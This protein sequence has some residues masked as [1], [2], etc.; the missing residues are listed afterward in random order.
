[1]ADANGAWHCTI[2]TLSEGNHSLIAT[3][4]DASGQIGPA[5]SALAITVDT[6]APNAP[7]MAVYSPAGQALSGS[8]AA[9]DMILKG[10]GE[11]NS[12][13]NILDGGKQVGS[14]HAADDGSWSFDT[15]QISKGF[16]SFASEA[17]DAAGNVS[18]ASTAN[19]IMVNSGSAVGLT[20]INKHWDHTLTIKGTADANSHIKVYDGSTSLGSVDTKADGTWNFTTSYAVSKAMHTYM[21]QEVDGAG[22]TVASSGTAVFGS[23]GSDTLNSTTS[24]DLLVGSGGHDTFVFAPNFGQDVI[25]DFRAAGCGHDVVQFSKTVFDSFADVLAHATQNGHDVVIAAGAA[26]SLTMKNVKINALDK[27]DF[28]FA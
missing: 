4:T 2:S 7:T 18:A 8:T 9:H 16:H 17:V 26:D 24:N 13:I 20:H 12:T 28:H 27:T 14:T 3:A 15:G 23:K 6:H 5:S 19:P 1:M 21:A 11:A 10:S 25:K 22:H